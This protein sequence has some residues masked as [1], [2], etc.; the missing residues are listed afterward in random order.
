MRT[1]SATFVGG[2]NMATALIGGLIEAGASADRFHVVEPFA[3]QRDR[4]RARFGGVHLHEATAAGALAGSDVVVLAVKPQQMREAAAALAPHRD[5]M[6]VVLSIAAGIRVDD[7]ARW[8]GGYRRIVR[9]MPNTPA[10][11][12]RGMSGVYADPEVDQNARAAA[13]QVLE[14]A[15]EVVWFEREQALDVV[16]G[17]SGSGPAYVFYLLEALE[18]AA[19]DQGLTRE[20]ARK[21]AYAT[22][23]GAVALAQQSTEEPA[24][25]RANVTSKGGTTERG[26]QV[27]AAR[28]VARAMR[29]AVAA[30]TARAKELGDELGAQEDA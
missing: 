27:L 4:L 8:L 1:L 11:I 22:F 15:G 9:A 26:L 25:L 2:G 14:A 16:T 5:T 18:Q 28:E 21:L 23:G 20:V 12:G 24:T 3:A 10:L 19:V 30:A 17:V 7:L 29:E 6:A 13:A